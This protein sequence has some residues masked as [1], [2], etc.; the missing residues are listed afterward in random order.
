MLIMMWC[1]D[2]YERDSAYEEDHNNNILWLVGDYLASQARTP[3]QIH[4]QFWFYLKVI[5]ARLVGISFS[6]ER[7]LKKDINNEMGVPLPLKKMLLQTEYSLNSADL[8][9]HFELMRIYLKVMPV[10]GVEIKGL[11]QIATG[12]LHG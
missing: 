8:Q 4:P 7:R 6:G 9:V 12:F 3:S 1:K 11:N 10:E 5:I 2:D